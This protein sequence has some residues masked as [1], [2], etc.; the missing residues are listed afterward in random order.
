MPR[1]V[2]CPVFVWFLGRITCIL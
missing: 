1:V 2:Y